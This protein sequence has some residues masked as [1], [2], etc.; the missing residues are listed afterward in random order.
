MF[1]KVLLGIMRTGYEVYAI[2]LFLN[3]FQ[4]WFEFIGWCIE[5][6]RYV[7]K[8]FSKNHNK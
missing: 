7:V 4:I 8:I 5:Q 6:I 1:E 3:S 2:I